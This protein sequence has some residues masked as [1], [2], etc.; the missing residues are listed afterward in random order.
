MSEHE[1]ARIRVSTIIPVYNGAATVAQAIDSA[2]AQEFDGQEIIVVNDGS[3]DRT[4]EVLAGYGDRI[5][6]IHQANGGIAAA[7]NAGIAIAR[8]EYVAF[9]DA[10]DEWL[11]GHLSSCA[12]LLDS[13]PGTVASYSAFVN[14]EKDKESVAPFPVKPLDSNALLQAGFIVPPSTVVVRVLALR[15]CGGFSSK[16]RRR[17]GFEDIYMWL[18]LSRSGVFRCTTKPA[19]RYSLQEFTDMGYKYAPGFRTFA[20]LTSK[21]FSPA[22][23]LF[24]LQMRIYLA[25]SLLLMVLD[26]LDAG[27]PKVALSALWRLIKLH[28]TYPL[29]HINLRRMFLPRNL[30]RIRN[31]ATAPLN[32]QTSLKETNRP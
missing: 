1:Q 26:R 14:V 23:E 15:K 30:S 18:L 10:D 16:F 20:R 7:R 25:S 3:T 17:I 13:D 12:A 21:Q 28:P 24:L 31:L 32:R 6:V 4:A 29:R 11:P 8:G 19:V 22:R 2:L 27:E 5:S 9:L